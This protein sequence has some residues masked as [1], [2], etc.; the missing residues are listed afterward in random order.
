VLLCS[1]HTRGHGCG[2]GLQGYRGTGSARRRWDV[3]ENTGA[4][5]LQGHGV[6]EK[7]M[8]RSGEH[9]SER[10]DMI[11][12]DNLCYCATVYCATMLYSYERP[13]VR[14]GATGLQ[15]H[16]VCKRRLDI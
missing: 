12:S 5:G 2:R 16:G 9:V 11:R 10:P 3:L 1:T 7:E 6:C 14:P 8:G 13:R 15:G 4:T